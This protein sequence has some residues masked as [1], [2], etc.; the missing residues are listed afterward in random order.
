MPKYH[1]SASGSAGTSTAT[2]TVDRV[3]GA[4]ADP[5][6][7]AMVERLSHG[8]SSVSELARPLSLSLPATL[9]HLRVLEASGLVRTEKRGRVRTCHLQPA[10]L[11]PVEAWMASRRAE[12]ERRLDRLGDFLARPVPDPIDVPPEGRSE[13]QEQQP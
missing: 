7:R 2:P 13:P 9:Q 12:W 3:F 1:A 5:G 10:G 8:P 6:R 4:L 11:A